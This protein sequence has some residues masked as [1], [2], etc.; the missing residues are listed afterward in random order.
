MSEITIKNH[1]KKTQCFLNEAETNL[2]EIVW[3]YYSLP[4]GGGASW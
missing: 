2:C 1:G 4:A 3:K